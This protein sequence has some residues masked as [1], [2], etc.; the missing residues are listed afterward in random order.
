LKIFFMHLLLLLS[1]PQASEAAFPNARDQ[2]LILERLTSEVHRLDGEGLQARIGKPASRVSGTSHLER[3]GIQRENERGSERSASF[4]A[5]FRSCKDRWEKRYP[6]FSIAYEGS[7]AC[8]FTKN[9][10]P[11][12]MV[13]RI[14]RFNYRKANPDHP[15]QN[16]QQEVDALTPFWLEHSAQVKTLII[17]LL[18][19]GGGSAPIPYYRLLMQKPFQEQSVQFRKVKEMES[20]VYREGLFWGESAQEL[21]FQKQIQSG[22]W[23]K[24]KWGEFSSSVPQFCADSNLPCDETL[25][26]PVAHSFRGKVKVLLNENCVSSCDGFAWMMS[27]ELGAKLYGFPAATDAAYSRVRLD[28]VEDLTH[29]DGFRIEVRDPKADLPPKFIVG[30]IISVSRTT[31]EKGALFNGFPLSLAREVP[32]RAGEFYPRKVLEAALADD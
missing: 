8:F 3:E 26:Q 29:P 1:A 5:N 22:A 6:G 28:A 14:V 17:D 12:K 23:D 25:F 24:L 30:E 7:L 19:N 10:D 31:V 27:S 2:R 32:Y 4:R 16:V 21:W 11:S 20:A 13:L 9:D 18:D 15:V